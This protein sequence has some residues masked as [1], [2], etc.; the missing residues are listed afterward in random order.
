MKILPII[1]E[2]F[3][4]ELMCSHQKISNQHNNKSYKRNKEMYGKLNVMKR[5]G[6][7]IMYEIIT[8]KII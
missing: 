8:H 2:M 5:C 3:T 6:D 4:D 7:E 1:I